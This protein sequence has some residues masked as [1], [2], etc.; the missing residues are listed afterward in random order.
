M[1]HPSVQ[2]VKD[3]SGQESLL[4]P[5]RNDAARIEFNPMPLS[6][7][8][9][10]APVDWIWEPYVAMGCCTLL[11]A[12]W[13]AGKTTLLAHILRDLPTG[14]GLVGKPRP[15]KV[16]V[17]SEERPILWGRRRDSLGIGDHVHLL[18]RPFRGR[19]TLREWSDL[20]ARI[21][22]RVRAG[23]YDLIIFDTIAGLWH[24]MDENNAGE[25][26]A[27]LMPLNELTSAGAAV[28]LCHHMRKGDGDQGQGG[29]GSG[30]LSGF[31]DV[32]VEVRRRVISDPT[33]RQ[34]VITSYSRLDDEA[35]SD[36]VIELSDSGYVAVG[37][38]AAA[39][40]AARLQA[41]Q[42]TL[43]T[44]PPGISLEEIR[45]GWKGAPPGLSTLR[46]DLKDGFVSG[47]WQRTGKGA[48]GSEY[49]Y[50][51]DRGFASRNSEPIGARNESTEPG[52]RA[53]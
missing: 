35:R 36:L 21:A 49:R 24:V 17:V 22:D 19:P 45:M 51:Q 34:R 29:R 33:N 50:W 43:P 39:Q 37:T 52:G 6:Q 31:V 38:T 1:N 27:A 14:G 13:K 9:P 10:S 48:R 11:N 12:F 18:A 2:A 16:L 26:M 53:T 28:L 5:L 7:I 15:V 8:G 30:A 3:W 20:I 42:A 44:V 41:L 23:A 25:M 47:R 40:S 32:I 46:T 4:A